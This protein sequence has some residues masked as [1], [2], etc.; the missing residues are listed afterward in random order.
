MLKSFSSSRI[1]YLKLFVL[2]ACLI[3]IIEVCTVLLITESN[4]RSIFANVIAIIADLFGCVGL[5]LAAK[6]SLAQS[7]KISIGWGIIALAVF[8]YFIADTFWLILENFLHEQPF[9]SLADL[10]YLIYYPLFLL[11]TFLIVG[12][13]KTH[14][15]YF[16]K[17]L[18]ICIVLVASLLAYWFLLF[19]PI[20]SS[21]ANESF[22]SQLI[23]LAYPIGDIVLLV[24]LFS[25]LYSDSK[26]KNTYPIIILSGS[27]LLIIVIDLIYSRQSL[28]GTYSSG[29]LLDIGWV[30]VFLLAGLSGIS[31]AVGLRVNEKVQNI[32]LKIKSSGK[33]TTIRFYLPYLWLIVLYILLKTHGFF[34]ESSNTIQY[35]IV[36]MIGLI[37]IKSI[38]QSID[39]NRNNNQLQSSN[40]YIQAQ[41]DKLK[42]ANQN[43]QIEITERALL[44]KKLS[45]DANHDALTG[46]AN[47]Y[48]FLDHLSQ[49][50]KNCN[51]HPQYQY[52]VLYLDIDNFKVIN[53][54]LGHLFGDQLL[55]SFA[56]RLRE[57]F[58]SNDT[59]ARLGGDEFLILMEYASD[60][61]NF[62]QVVIRKIQ[63]LIQIPFKIEKK[64]IHLTSSIGVVNN[65]CNYSKPEEVIR[66]A[67]TAM[68]LAKTSGKACYKLFASSMH[69]Q[70]L[71]RLDIENELHLGLKNKEF[72]LYFQPILCLKDNQLLGFE[73][74]LRWNHPKRGLLLPGKF[75]DVAEESGLIVEIGEWVLIQSCSQLKTWQ[76]Q[77]PAIKNLF[78]NV[79]LSCKQFAQPNL[80]RQIR[81]ALRS[82]KLNGEYL[83]L[84]ITETVLVNNFEK[85]QIYLNKLAELGIQ[86]QIDDFGTGYS[87]LG[88]LQLLPIKTI[89]IDRSFIQDIGVNKRGTAFVQGIMSMAK[90][91]DLETVAEGIETK[92][93]LNALI[94]MSCSLGQGYLFDK[95][96]DINSVEKAL[97]ILAS[98]I[99]K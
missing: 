10:F 30:V 39:L 46:L 55:I 88:Y 52:A 77:F 49:S 81:K 13:P 44:E 38:K 73:A 41:T 96:L 84:E 19:E 45:H 3:F 5:F 70:A 71:S 40:K 27:I 58:R 90:G 53:D 87:S 8:S 31:Q 89:K 74:L 14:G 72:Q 51:R 56:R 15:E 48:Y 23:L 34:T 83:R 37:S 61:T 7:R 79:N 42:N 1:N 93:Q 25:I 36:G 18:D 24:S 28:L 91:L 29:G 6:Q 59:I 66:D 78:V 9:P 57:S 68:Y 26:M 98:S 2:I 35:G 86:C 85:A 17:A 16:D 50:I 4:I 82:S 64:E 69:T 65:V 67:D 76:M 47:R 95:P 11:G 43:L 80:I 92:E 33:M 97:S 94:K 20:I 12:T 62:I 99:T 22:L 75:L 21:S 63:K 54:S 32:Y 60:E